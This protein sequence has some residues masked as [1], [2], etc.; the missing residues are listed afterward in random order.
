MIYFP[1][2]YGTCRGAN[3]AINMAIKVK[4]EN[5]DKKVLIYKEILH[6]NYVVNELNKI[7]IEIVSELDNVTKN[8]LVII[9]AHGETKSTFDYLDKKG[10]KYYD[11]TC[12][13]V[14]KI[15]DIV[16]DKKK[17]YKIIIVG[18]KEHP[19]VI[20]TNGWADN[21]A[22]IIEDENDYKLLNKD[23][24]YF[25][26]SQTTISIDSVNNL[27]KYMDKNGINYKSENTICNY[28]KL[29]QLSSVE[30]AKNMNIMIVIGGKNS[31]NTKELFNECQKVCKNTYFFSEIEEFYEFIKTHKFKLSDKIGF[32]G[33]ASTMKEQILEYS[34]LLE[35]YIYYT[36]KKKDIE[37]EI[38]KFNKVIKSSKNNKI[39][40]DALDKFTYMNFD[41]KCI[42]GTLIDLG[43]KTLK[44]DNNALSLS[45]SYEA[46]ETSILIHDDI[47]DNSP[48]R[49]G[50][51]TIHELYKDEFNGLNID[52][53]PTSLAICL[54]DIGLFYI[55]NYMIDKY[56]NNKNLSKIL[57]CYNNI[58]ID[59]IK[60]EILDVY[61]PFIEKN[62]KSH[63]LYEED[64]MEIYRLKTSIY[65]IVGPFTLGMILSNN[66]ECDIKEMQSI[67]MP[68]GIAFQ[69]KDDIIGIFSS[70]DI[71]GK[72][73][74]SDIE[75]FKQT[76]LYS[77][78]KI[79]KPE[80]LNK[81]L[82]IYGKQN[83]KKEEYNEIKDILIN[84]GSLEYAN[85]KMIELFNESKE[86]LL[87]SKIKNEVKNILLGFI[88]Y[89][90]LRKK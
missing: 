30:L 53:T 90:E 33:G 47:I 56:K 68:L 73:N 42:R 50:K 71:I 77:Y 83:I 58:V 18:K 14:K 63:L 28:Q 82:K 52:N 24:N 45:A 55:Y 80:Y 40:D 2:I 46:F 57:T 41:G 26:V 31:S 23:E 44:N 11:A 16:L 64:I 7:G 66:K 34:N 29:I 85:N 49:R 32:N 5:P 65:T 78:I 15:H 61:L 20:A 48:L 43:Y 88:K 25:L 22:I 4:K 72:P 74:Y 89:L 54:G 60:G 13:N 59:T 21:N 69:I 70:S 39:V 62:D 10:I 17:D 1:K 12:I 6:N 38:K 35:F 81:L 51:K 27:V 8:D 67:L 3:N 9:R 84:S 86:K 37:S 19:E 79:R 36:N 75:E 87:N 76:I